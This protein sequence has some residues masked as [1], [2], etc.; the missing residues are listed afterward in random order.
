M[1]TGTVGLNRYGETKLPVNS[2][3]VREIEVARVD[4]WIGLH[5]AGLANGWCSRGWGAFHW[6]GL[7]TFPP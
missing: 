3:M 1:I 6:V 5:W 7:A 4:V 2:L